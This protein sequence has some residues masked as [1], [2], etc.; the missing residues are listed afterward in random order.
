MREVT[1]LDELVALVEDR[2]DEL[3][4]RWSVGPSD[5]PETSRDA[6]TGVP[7]PGLSA[8]ALAIEPWWAGRSPRL[9]VARRLY[10]Y[11]HLPRVRG[12]GVRPWVLAGEE[13]GRGPDNEPLVVCHEPVAW[14]A[15][16]VLDQARDL[17]ASR[18]ANWGPLDR[19][20]HGDE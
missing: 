19:E 8:N 7:L 15:D 3:F 5:D 16:S 17:I 13:V 11:H 4:I 20:S 6:L 1:D 14:I 18:P 2:G 9:W 10:D 12:A